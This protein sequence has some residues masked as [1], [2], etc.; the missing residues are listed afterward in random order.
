MALKDWLDTGKCLVGFHEG[1]WLRENTRSCVM[2]Q[3]CARCGNISQR[4][5]HDWA[6]WRYPSPTNCDLARSC[7]RCAENETQ[8]EHQLGHLDLPRRQRMRTGRSV[9][10]LFDVERTEPDRT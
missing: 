4:V 9:H 1:N 2:L 3:T 5:E 7:K 6:E 8:I 10:T